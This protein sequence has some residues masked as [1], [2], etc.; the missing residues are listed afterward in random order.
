M[1]F[2]FKLTRL[3][4]RSGKSKT[5][6]KVILIERNS[7]TAYD[8]TSM[9]KEEYNQHVDLYEKWQALVGCLAKFAGGR[10]N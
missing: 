1:L 7:I 6:D 2:N 4:I 8:S 3:V 10:G 5:Q 9:N